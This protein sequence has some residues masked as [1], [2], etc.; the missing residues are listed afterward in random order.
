MTIN[1][2]LNLLL[3]SQDA[4]KDHYR[5][6]HDGVIKMAT[7]TDSG[8]LGWCTLARPI[9]GMAQLYSCYFVEHENGGRYLMVSNLKYAISLRDRVLTQLTESRVY[10]G[11][12][13][14]SF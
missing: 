12:A 14:L 5:F 10:R 11:G 4:V 13:R 8:L 1:D 9:P 7:L 2:E 3:I 6:F